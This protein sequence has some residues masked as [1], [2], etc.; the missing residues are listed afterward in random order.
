M[1][2]ILGILCIIAIS[3]LIALCYRKRLSEVYVIA[4]G[5]IVLILYIAGIFNTLRVGI[6]IVYI[7]S[8]LCMA[9]SVYICLRYGIY[10]NKE[11]NPQ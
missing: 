11:L 3:L 5:V 1:T 8:A 6:F 9:G 4:A 2:C 7:V 10:K